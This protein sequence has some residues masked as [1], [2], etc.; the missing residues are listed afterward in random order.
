LTDGGSAAEGPVADSTVADSTLTS[1]AA[2]G[3]RGLGHRRRR[4]V[5]I[6]AI[7]A[8]VLIADQITKTLAVEHLSAHRVHLIGPFYLAL[9]YN[10]G[11]AFS[12][13]TGLTLPIILIAVAIV[14]LIVWL[15][16][17]SL[18]MLT[19]VAVGLILGG[20]LG[21]L[22]DRIFRG[23]HGAVVDFFYSRFWPTFNVADSCIVV[24][25]FLLAFS[26]W[27]NRVP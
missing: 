5:L 14:A 3:S 10:T 18:S 2:P 17:R 22:S 24:G 13:G 20:A 21:N 1:P 15:A 19:G 8:V 26:L 9:S 4:I 12:L 6:T 16:R 27:R 23:H 7:T 25:S 11:V